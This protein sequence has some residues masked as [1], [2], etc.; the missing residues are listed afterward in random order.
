MKNKKCNIISMRHVNHQFSVISRCSENIVRGS[1]PS[2]FRGSNIEIEL[3]FSEK[4]QIYQPYWWMTNAHML[5]MTRFVHH[6]D[7]TQD[8]ERA[9][10]VFSFEFA[11]YLRCSIVEIFTWKPVCNAT[12]SQDWFTWIMRPDDN[13][14]SKVVSWRIHGSIDL[15]T[16]AVYEAKH[17]YAAA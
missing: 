11:M 13:G 7:F 1:L 5:R 4:P 17:L 12:I 9:F 8:L 10:D 14:L 3:W 16:I 2:A 6:N 15:L